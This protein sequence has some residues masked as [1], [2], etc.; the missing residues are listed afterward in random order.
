MR[1]NT[2]TVRGSSDAAVTESSWTRAASAGTSGS[3]EDER[4]ALG[5]KQI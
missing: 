5:L 4:G 1:G 2:G 3:R